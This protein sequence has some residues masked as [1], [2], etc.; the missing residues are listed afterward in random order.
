MLSITLIA[1]IATLAYLV[2]KRRASEATALS[3]GVN[4]TTKKDTDVDMLA[5]RA[6]AR[7]YMANRG[8]RD[9]KALYT[10]VPR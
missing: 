1:L 10:S 6:N 8:I 3:G 4:H 5:K 2:A 7:R 9:V